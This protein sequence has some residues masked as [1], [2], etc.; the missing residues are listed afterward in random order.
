MQHFCAECW[1]TRRDITVLHCMIIN[2]Y[3]LP[4][5]T[6]S[7]VEQVISKLINKIVLNTNGFRLILQNKEGKMMYGGSREDEPLTLQLPLVL[8]DEHFYVARSSGSKTDEGLC[9]IIVHNL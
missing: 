1:D 2:K 3:P 9:G 4:I 8:H 6:A 7:C 5:S